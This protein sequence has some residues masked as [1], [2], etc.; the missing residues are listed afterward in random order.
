MCQGH[1]SGEAQCEVLAPIPAQTTSPEWPSDGVT[2]MLE[3]KER[4]YGLR[5]QVR[6][7]LPPARCV[8]L[9]QYVTS[10]VSLSAEWK[11]QAARAQGFSRTP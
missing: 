9:G 10:P 6:L 4:R 7:A 8:T 3:H 11:Q 2:P 1:T 5:G